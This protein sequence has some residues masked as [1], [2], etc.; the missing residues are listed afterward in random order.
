MRN[1]NF[2]CSSFQ[3]LASLVLLLSFYITS[4]SEQ[5][6]GPAVPGTNSP[7]TT[8]AGNRPLQFPR[9]EGL[10][11]DKPIE[12][13]YLNSEFTDAE[14]KNYAFFL[15]KFSTGR[16]LVSLFDKAANKTWA[17]DYYE[18]VKAAED[19]LDLSSITGRWKQTVVPFNYTV[20]FDYEG[21]TLNLTLKA[22]KKPFLPGGDGFIAMGEKGTSYYYA[23]TDL[24][25]SGTLKAGTNAPQQQV[26]GK[27]WIDHQWGNWDWVNDFSQWKWYSVK[28]DN[29]VDLM[30]F[31]IY[32]NKKV[33][34]SHCGYIDKANNQQHKLSCQLA[35]AKYYTDAKGG[36][37][38]KEVTLEIPGIPN[39]RLT[40][41][42][43]NDLQ[44][45]EPFVLWEGTMK[46]EGTF[47]GEKVKGTAYQ[48][49]NR[50]D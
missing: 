37:W 48:E 46:V 18:S 40:L 6:P 38:Q 7:G 21:M 41:S 22:N 28:L 10:H 5:K 36:R 32:K 9:D 25:L 47:K 1:P 43:E 30:L 8:A 20:A 35:T 2:C 11:A 29:G 33:L 50:A 16:H 19:R 26:S 27:A 12:W 4:C 44:F 23:L 17:K 34:N 14:G 31:N 24:S 49:L 45:V 3:R 15:C 13:W 39:T 42:S